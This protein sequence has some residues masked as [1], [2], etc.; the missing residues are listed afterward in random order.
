MSEFKKFK[1][2]GLVT[3][4]LAMLGA[5]LRAYVEYINFLK[6]VYKTAKNG[7]SKLIEA[8]LRKDITSSVNQFPQEVVRGLK[9]KAGNRP[10]GTILPSECDQVFEMVN[11][12]RLPTQAFKIQ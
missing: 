10:Q 2:S 7:N 11:V 6:R 9:R 12:N 8:N 3:F 1:T 5:F 4:S